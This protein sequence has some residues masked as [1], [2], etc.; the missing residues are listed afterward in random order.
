MAGVHCGVKGIRRGGGGGSDY[1]P[2]QVGVQSLGL[3]L[4]MKIMFVTWP[5]AFS[6][7]SGGGPCGVDPA[8][9]WPRALGKWSVEFMGWGENGG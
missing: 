6:V 4:A 1:S 9:A 3:L 2:S 5:V 7:R 8:L